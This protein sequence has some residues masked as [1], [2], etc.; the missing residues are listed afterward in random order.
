MEQHTELGSF[1]ILEINFDLKNYFNRQ[2]NIEIEI[3]YKN[4]NEF[5]QNWL[6]NADPTVETILETKI[7]FKGLE[8]PPVPQHT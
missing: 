5:H 4:K 7:N 1:Q 8:T 2:I 6:L 3:K